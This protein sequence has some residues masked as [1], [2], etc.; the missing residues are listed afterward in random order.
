MSA[1][2]S[3][4][5]PFHRLLSLEITPIGSPPA[6]RSSSSRSSVSRTG[7]VQLGGLAH[8][9]SDGVLPEELEHLLHFELLRVAGPHHFLLFIDALLHRRSQVGNLFLELFDT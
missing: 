6:S 3:E 8:H 4:R 5:K 2:Q 9:A 1:I 7:L